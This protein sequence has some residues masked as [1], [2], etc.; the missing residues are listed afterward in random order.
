M[1]LDTPMFDAAIIPPSAATSTFIGD[2]GRSP[3]FT[4]STT[5]PSPEV[6]NTPNKLNST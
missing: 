6:L 2:S 3:S 1:Y 5:D 4:A